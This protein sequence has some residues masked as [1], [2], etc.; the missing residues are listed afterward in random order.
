MKFP[1]LAQC[2]PTRTN[3]SQQGPKELLKFPNLVPTFTEIHQFHTNMTPKATE[4]HQF[5]PQCPKD[6]LKFPNSTKTKKK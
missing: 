1:N 6:L 5:A 4:I 3:I 2:P